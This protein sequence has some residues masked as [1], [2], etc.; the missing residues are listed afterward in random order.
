MDSPLLRKLASVDW[1]S[2]NYD[3]ASAS[4]TPSFSANPTLHESAE[5]SRG[6]NAASSHIANQRSTSRSSAVDLASLRGDFPEEEVSGNRGRKDERL[7][8]TA[9]VS[10]DEHRSLSR[11][12]NRSHSV[13]LSALRG[14]FPEE[15]SFTDR[16]RKEERVVA[17]AHTSAL[18]SS[19]RSSAVDLSTLRGDFPEEEDLTDRVRKEDRMATTAH[20]SNLRSTSRSSAT[21]PAINLSSLRGDFPDDTGADRGRKEERRATS[22]YRDLSNHRSLSRSSNRTAYSVDLSTLREDF[23]DAYSESDQW[24]K[25]DK[26]LPTSSPTV[27]L[28]K[29]VSIFSPTS[30]FSPSQQNINLTALRG[31]Y[32]DG[33]D[34]FEAL[35]KKSKEAP[36]TSTLLSEKK[37]LNS[38][39][40]KIH[41]VYYPDSDG[42]DEAE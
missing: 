16:G 2:I 27:I 1:H 30:S 7:A 5:V 35:N 42:V 37:Q 15:E 6:R 31:D 12:S 36:A 8:V 4:E 32:P 23:P 34:E 24:E 21:A 3:V 22:S 40:E 14:D 13:D 25:K 19:S 18:R 20:P 41:S 10:S 26:D 29:T 39:P 38:G 17:P 9:H 11:S 28:N 33:T